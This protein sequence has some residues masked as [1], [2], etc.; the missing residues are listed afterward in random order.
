[1]KA[2]HG[3]PALMTFS[4]FLMTA[5]V[6]AA[7]INGL[8]TKTT[9]ADPDNVTIF[10]RENGVVKAIG[11][12][13][14]QGKKNVWYAEGEIKEPR[15]QLSYH[16]SAATAPSGWAADGKMELSLSADGNTISGVAV[17]DSGDWSGKIEFRRVRIV[18]PETQ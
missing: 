13:T 8:W 11:Y 1:M 5:S 3:L 6:F 9:N 14:L 10:Y 12:S 2:I 7:D 4:W 18:S 15:L 17:S 16:Y